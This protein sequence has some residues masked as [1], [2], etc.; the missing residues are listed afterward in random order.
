[1]LDVKASK[2]DSRPSTPA[3]DDIAI[4]V[5]NVSKMYPLY[6]NPQ[7]RLKQSLWYTLPKFLRGKPRQFY[8]EFWALHDVSF[9]LE[10]GKSLGIVGRNGSGKSTLLQIIAGTLAPTSG[11]V[12]INGKV[13]ALL[14][15]SSGFNPEFTGRENIYMNGTIWGMTQTQIDELYDDIV[16]F[17]DIG[18]FINQP[19]QLYSSGM[20][21]RLAFAVQAFVPK[22]TLIVDEALSVGDVAF[23]RKCLAVMERFRDNGGTFIYVSHSTQ[24]IVQHCDRCLLLSQGELL[25]DGPAK[26]VTD[27]YEKLIFSPPD[28]MRL[29]ISNI[30]QSGWQQS[31]NQKNVDSDNKSTI[32]AQN[33]LT[34]NLSNDKQIEPTKTRQTPPQDLGPTDYLDP[35]MP[36]PETVVYGNLAAKITDFSIYNAQN[37]QVNVLVTGRRYRWAVNVQFYSGAQDI[38]FGLMIKTKNGISLSPLT[39]KRLGVAVSHVSAA[40][41]VE[42]SFEV[43]LNLVPGAYFYNLGVATTEDGELTFLHRLVDAGMF[44]VLAPDSRQLTGI[45]YLEPAFDY[46]ITEPSTEIY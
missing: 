25:A 28:K 46:K 24:S 10:P 8:R 38:H 14:E 17:A 41:R 15:L 13:A 40:T 35:N 5:R 6:K 16:A 29:L 21:V 1:M 31:I 33:S 19:V 42:I 26:P 32:Q 22:Q 23:Q 39:N 4:S 3:P 36:S 37:Q 30:K 11:E 9:D 12:H 44:R 27:L 34:S 43:T 18:Q 7:E 45:V 20:A 2:L